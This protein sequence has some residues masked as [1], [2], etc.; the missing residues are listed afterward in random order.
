MQHQSA[1][2]QKMEL[3]V[4]AVTACAADLH[5]PEEWRWLEIE[6]QNLQR[7]PLS[8]G[9]RNI[10]WR[11]VSRPL[12]IYS[13]CM[14][15]RRALVLAW[16]KT[17]VQQFAVAGWV[18]MNKKGVFTEI[19]CSALSF[20]QA[21]GLSYQTQSLIFHPWEIMSFLNSEFWLNSIT[22]FRY[23]STMSCGNN[24]ILEISEQIL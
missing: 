19:T 2:Q 22:W 15:I 6:S 10:S 17:P 12:H 13:I 8:S 14:H 5:V 20:W 4:V 1:R 18:G 16:R 21:V 23:W 7:L 11:F 3:I 24:C 9:S